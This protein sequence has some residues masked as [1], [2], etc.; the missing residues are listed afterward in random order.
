MGINFGQQSVDLLSELGGRQRE[1]VNGAFH[2]LEQIDAHKV[3]QAFFTVNLFEY[4]FACAHGFIVTTGVFGLFGF[5]H[6]FQ[7]RITRQGQS[8]DGFVDVF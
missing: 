8:S 3:N 7:R 5:A 4:P 6:E 2:A 1:R